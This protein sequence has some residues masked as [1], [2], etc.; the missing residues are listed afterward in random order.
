MTTNRERNADAATGRRARRPRGSLT[1]DA[2]VEA[3]L[4]LVDAEGVEALSMPRLARQLEAGVMTLYGYV[5]GK[6][7]LLDAVA[8]R[9]I[10]EVRVPGLRTGDWRAILLGWGRGIRKVLL[11][12]P[13]VA[14][15]LIQRSV[16]GAGIF[17]GAEV[18][19][20]P[21][22]QNGFATEEAARAIYAVLI[23]TLG[24]VLWETPRTRQQ[25]EGAYA[26]Q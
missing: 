23:Y 24:F 12:H 20:G 18:L 6:Q 8:M 26:A 19:L 10:A 25:P 14:G 11:A 5:R 16:L 22:Q 15:V 1:R 7:E 17:R 13:G 9:A 4:A 2:V 3:A 21:L